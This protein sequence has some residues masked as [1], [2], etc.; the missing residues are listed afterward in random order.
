MHLPEE[1]QLCGLAPGYILATAGSDEQEGLEL[2]SASYA[3]LLGMTVSYENLEDLMQEYLFSEVHR[4]N[5]KLLYLA[6]SE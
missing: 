6:F 2:R 1:M 5:L 3:K 4:S